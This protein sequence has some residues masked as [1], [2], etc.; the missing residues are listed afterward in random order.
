M[1]SVD[2][3]MVKCACPD[4]VCVVSVEKAVKRDE[5]AFCCDECADGHPDHSGCDH[6][7][8]ACHG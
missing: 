1:A 8:C 7:G 2:V 6:A 5:K 3:N 4:C